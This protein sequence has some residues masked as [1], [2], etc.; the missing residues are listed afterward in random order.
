[1][2]LWWTPWRV[3]TAARTVCVIR[4]GALRS[5]TQCIDHY[6]LMFIKNC[7][8][9]CRYSP[10]HFTSFYSITS[11]RITS[12]DISSHHHQLDSIPSLLIIKITIN[13]NT[14][15]ILLALVPRAELEGDMTDQQMG[16][17]ARLMSKALRKITGALQPIGD[18][19]LPALFSSWNKWLI[20]STY[21]ESPILCIDINCTRFIFIFIQFFCSHYI[22][23]QHQLTLSRTLTNIHR[24][25]RLSLEISNDC[26]FYQSVTL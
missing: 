17:Q 8:F 19:L 26:Y 9:R 7:H 13:N 18:P 1:M 24:T 3:C 15:I 22:P 11:Y 5:Q 4:V 16:L 2:S 23:S 12:H 25:R 10:S 21:I 6:V 20:S 14:N